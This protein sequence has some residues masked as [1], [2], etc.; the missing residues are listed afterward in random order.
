MGFILYSGQ[1]ICKKKNNIKIG[2]LVHLGSW[3]YGLLTSQS[4]SFSELHKLKAGG[5]LKKKRIIILGDNSN[6][7]LSSSKQ[8]SCLYVLI[9]TT[10]S[11]LIIVCTCYYLVVY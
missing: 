4:L 9:Y 10:V 11:L 8:K 1:P 2:S 6:I 5:M 3:E 7:S